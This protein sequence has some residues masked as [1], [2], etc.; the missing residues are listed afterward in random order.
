MTF[1]IGDF[2]TF[3]QC[4]LNKNFAFI[5]FIKLFKSLKITPHFFE[6]GLLA[7]CRAN[8]EF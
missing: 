4:I 2:F 3:L 6:F 8:T 7:V 5:D 1:V